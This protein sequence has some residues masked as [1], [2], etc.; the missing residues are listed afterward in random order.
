MDD[1]APPYWTLISVLFSSIPLS[2]TLAM[3]LHETACDLYRRDEA[4][5]ALA[6][7]MLDGRLRS[8]KKKVLMGT[9]GGPLFEAEIETE[10][11]SGK[12][13][14]LVTD[15]GLEWSAR[16]NGEPPP[17]SLLN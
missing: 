10:R 6:G 16:K 11:G 9:I 14:F 13:R 5:A 8:L 12:V 1:E 15:A 7:D 2:P 3:Y 4:S 17:P